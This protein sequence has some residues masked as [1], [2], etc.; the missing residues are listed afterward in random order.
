MYQLSPHIRIFLTVNIDDNF[1]KLIGSVENSRKGG[2][3]Q[4]QWMCVCVW[5][6][7]YDHVSHNAGIFF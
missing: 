3:S 4:S 5:V 7:V 6:C 2:L 1:L